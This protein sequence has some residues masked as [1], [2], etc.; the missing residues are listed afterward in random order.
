[1]ADHEIE[2]DLDEAV[3][4]IQ[5]R[6]WA[7]G[8]WVKEDGSM[9]LMGALRGAHVVRNICG[10]PEC[11]CWDYDIEKDAYPALAFLERFLNEHYEQRLIELYGDPGG[12]LNVP[13]FNDTVIK[14]E[15][16]AVAVLEKARARAAEEGI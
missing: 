2:R 5:A 7:Q 8:D 12:N 9:C 15:A 13:Y 3:V 16:E 11:E 4:R 10:N 1:M 14:T 6:G